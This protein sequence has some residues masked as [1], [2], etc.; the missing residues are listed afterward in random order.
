MPAI[1]QQVSVLAT[2][3]RRPLIFDLVAESFEKLRRNDA[4][5]N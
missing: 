5:V 4:S 2:T 3:Y 1:E